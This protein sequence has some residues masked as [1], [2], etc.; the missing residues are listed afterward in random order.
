M[1]IKFLVSNKNEGIVRNI[2]KG[3]L[4]ARG[5]WIK[6][7]AGDDIMKVSCIEQNVNF[8][9]KEKCDLVFL[10]GQSSNI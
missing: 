10:F 6:G 3:Y 4:E 1:R 7:I 8:V 5:H 2:N 9:Q